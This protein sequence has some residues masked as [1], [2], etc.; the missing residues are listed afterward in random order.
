MGWNTKRSSGRVAHRDIE[1]LVARAPL[2]F[3]VVH[4]EVRVTQQ[5]LGLPIVGLAQGHA[6]AGGRDELPTFDRKRGDE[7]RLDAPRRVLRI[8]Q[9]ADLLEQQGELVTA[10]PRHHIA[11]P[12]AGA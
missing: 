6:D 8:G 2:L 11:R 9:S 1:H 12:H 3:G 10:E 4:R 5:V 7:R